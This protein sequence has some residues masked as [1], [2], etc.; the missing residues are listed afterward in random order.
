MKLAVVA[1]A[2]FVFAAAPRQGAGDDVAA[3]KQRLLG[4]WTLVKYEVFGP[5]GEVR[6]GNTM[7]AASCT[8]KAAR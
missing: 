4:N 6:A 1:V 2:V 8:A 7:S 5:D 3:V